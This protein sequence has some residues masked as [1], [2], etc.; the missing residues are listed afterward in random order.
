MNEKVL[1]MTAEQHAF[2][3]DMGQLMTGWGI[4]RNTGRIWGYL[5]LHQ[6]PA[7]LDEIAGELEI[8][9]S[10]VSVATR[11]LVQLGLARGIGE[12]GSRRLLYEALSDLE[13]IFAARNAGLMA[14]LQTLRQGA[15]AA[16]AGVGK[17]RLSA[18]ATMVQEFVDMVPTLLRQLREMRDTPDRKKA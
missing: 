3:E 2:V 15:E 9:K 1:H 10:G 6:R 7:N 11:Q 14:L 13:G 8:A 17:E 12:R 5:L 16:A 4:A 18:M